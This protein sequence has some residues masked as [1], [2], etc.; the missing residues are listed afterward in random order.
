MLRRNEKIRRESMKDYGFG[1]DAMKS[2]KVCSRCGEM[3]TAS[4]LFCKECGT[5]LPDENLYQLYVKKHRCCEDC[6][7]V[8][9]VKMHY[10]PDCGQR[11]E[12]L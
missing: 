9:N 12:V 10:C 1:I 11:L 8:V 7:T 4:Q 6:G 3:A 2:I 5:A